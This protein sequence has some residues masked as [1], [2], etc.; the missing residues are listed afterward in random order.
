MSAG[1]DPAGG[2]VYAVSVPKGYRIGPWQVREPLATGS[3]GSVYAA[4]RTA[5]GDPELP[6]RAA[7]KFLP[8]GTHTPRQL[9]HLRELAE[10]EVDLLRKLRSPR[11]I[12]MYDVLTVDDAEHPALDGATVL[13]LEE[14]A[15]SLDVLL[16][17]SHRPQSGPALLAQIGDGLRQLHHA[18]WVHG[19]LK[20]ANVLLMKDGSSCLAD[21]NM[22]AELEGTHAYTPAFSTPDYTPPELLWSEIGERG[23]QIRPTADIWAFGVLAHLVLTGTYPLP[24]GTPSARRDAA[25]RYARGTDEL[26][27]SPELPPP[28]HALITDCLSRT[29]A[30]RAAHDAP[31]VLRRAEEAAG[32]DRAPRL[33]RRPVP[34]T[35]RVRRALLTTVTAAATFTALGF[36]LNALLDEEDPGTPTGGPKSGYARC[37]VGSVC[38]F[39]GKDGQGQMCT[40][41]GDDMN[42]LTG[43][44]KCAWTAQENPRSIYNN[45][46]DTDMGTKF[47]DVVYFAEPELAGKSLGCVEVQTKKNLTP[48]VK[49]LSHRWIEGC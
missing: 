20:P 42:W 39:S 41:V 16:A 24:G 31:S 27:L 36:G 35:R 48:P 40:W 18:G 6:R 23:Q 7:L 30:E 28:W 22:A 4:R 15:E 37:V 3:F 44:G 14:A 19:D 17:R 34:G 46:H 47:V 13:V 45:G 25:I 2:L 32:A 9:N 1:N 10:R 12:R 49:P 5:S 21:F 29:H 33:P 8:T 26:R 11:L 43:D 38:A